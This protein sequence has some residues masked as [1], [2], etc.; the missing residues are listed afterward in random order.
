MAVRDWREDADLDRAFAGDTDGTGT[1][2]TDDDDDDD[3]E[4]D[5]VEIEA[6][7][8]VGGGGGSFKDLSRSKSDCSAARV[9]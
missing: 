9:K 3:G 6:A 2:D 5:V 4:D 8:D 7:E 1:F